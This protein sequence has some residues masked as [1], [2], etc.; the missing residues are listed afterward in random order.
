MK[1][2]RSDWGNK[3]AWRSFQIKETIFAKTQCQEGYSEFRGLKEDSRD[4]CRAWERAWYKVR[5]RGRMEKTIIHL[6]GFHPTWQYMGSWMTGSGSLFKNIILCII[7]EGVHQLIRR[8]K[9]TDY[10][11]VPNQLSRCLGRGGKEFPCLERRFLRGKMLD[12]SLDSLE[13]CIYIAD[14]VW[15]GSGGQIK[16]NDKFIPTSVFLSLSLCPSI[17]F[18][19]SIYSHNLSC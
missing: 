17:S 10:Y 4:C 3:S 1:P 7:N 5:P 13:F 12:F 19:T 9:I 8:D 14:S 6:V 11:S 16:S 18:S 15:V 2:L